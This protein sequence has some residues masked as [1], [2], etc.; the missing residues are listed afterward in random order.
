MKSQLTRDFS[1]QASFYT[2]LT[3]RKF[4]LTF[5]LQEKRGWNLTEHNKA[6]LHIGHCKGMTGLPNFQV[7]LFLFQLVLIK[8]RLIL[9]ALRKLISFITFVQV[10]LMSLILF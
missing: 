7:Y 3:N 6:W 5:V 4:P 1:F 9:R 8:D 10:F 2:H